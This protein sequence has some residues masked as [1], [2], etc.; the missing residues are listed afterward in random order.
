MCLRYVAIA[1]S[2]DLWILGRIRGQCHP[3]HTIPALMACV[4]W[5]YPY[6][7]AEMTATKAT[8]KLPIPVIVHGWGGRTWLTLRT[9]KWDDKGMIR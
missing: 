7:K 1:S 2:L 4:S 5:V 6:T 3:H 8:C 9:W